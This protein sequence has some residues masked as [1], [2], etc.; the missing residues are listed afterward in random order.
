MQFGDVDAVAA[1]QILKVQVGEGGRRLQGVVERAAAVG[2]F[3]HLAG[4]VVLN[5]HHPGS[6]QRVGAD[7]IV[8][9]VE[10]VVVLGHR[11][12]G[13]ERARQLTQF[14]RRAVD[15]QLLQRHVERPLGAED[16][17]TAGKA[18]RSL[19]GGDNAGA[20]MGAHSEGE[21]VAGDHHA[22]LAV[23]LRPNLHSA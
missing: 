11:L 21:A 1:D 2:L 18:F 15:V 7:A 8:A 13:A 4:A 19:R 10:V 9:G 16:E 20:V 6:A 14:Q 12:R 3:R 23:V 22:V 17:E 5:Q